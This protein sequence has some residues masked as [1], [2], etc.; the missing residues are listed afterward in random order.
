LA[1][2]TVL[3]LSGVASTSMGLVAEEWTAQELRRMK[4][5]GW[6]LVNGLQLR[7]K[8]DTDHVLIGPAG[9]FVVETKWSSE[10]WPIHSSGNGFMSHRMA[11]AIQQVQ[12][13]RTDIVRHFSRNL[14][15]IQVTA[16][17]ILWAPTYER[18]QISICEEEERV[19]IVEG[20][21]LRSWLNSLNED[22]IDLGRVGQVWSAME[23]QVAKR[24][25][26][27][28]DS[29]LVA[30]PTLRHIFLAG[31]LPALIGALLASYCSI[32]GAR[33]AGSWLPAILT[34]AALPLLGLV[35]LRTGPLKPA[36]WGWTLMSSLLLV[37]FVAEAARIH[38]L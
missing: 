13:R 36:A 25:Q 17:C 38:A 31:L 3:L 14:E 16:V 24:D 33:V 7:P 22:A 8:A 10:S 11:R 34:L 5:K 15:G 28:F 2:V 30:R 19:R 1:I 37:V 21:S 20:P 4:S 27:D 29:G 12:D 26:Y 18:N 6:K 32:L 9:V 35:W 23:A